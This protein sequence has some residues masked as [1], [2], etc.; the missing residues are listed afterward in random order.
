MGKWTTYLTRSFSNIFPYSCRCS[1]LEASNVTESRVYHVASCTHNAHSVRGFWSNPALQQLNIYS[2]SLH[3][4]ASGATTGFKTSLDHSLR[5]GMYAG[6]YKLTN[7]PSSSSQ[8]WGIMH[9]PVSAHLPEVL[10]SQ[11][12]RKGDDWPFCPCF[13]IDKLYWEHQAYRTNSIRNSGLA[14]RNAL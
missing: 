11:I 7:F 5:C 14:N 1:H 9:I 10:S 6:P 2:C 3:E 8:P 13:C 12:I 4:R